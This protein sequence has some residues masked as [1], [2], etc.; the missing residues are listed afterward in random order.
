MGTFASAKSIAATGVALETAFVGA[1][2]GAVEALTS[3]DLK[4]VAGQIG[5]NE[6]Q[7]LTTFKRLDG[8]QHPR[9]QPLLP[10]EPHRRPGDRR[11]DPPPRMSGGPRTSP[12]PQ[13]VSR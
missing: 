1:Y 5:A 6:A 3:N 13:E 10:Q 2:L 9:P 12:T 7:H 11:R 4:A 8:G